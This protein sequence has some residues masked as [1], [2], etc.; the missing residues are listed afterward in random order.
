MI[1]Q[2]HIWVPQVMNSHWTFRS[3]PQS[4]S[5]VSWPLL[6]RWTTFVEFDLVCKFL[7]W[8]WSLLGSWASTPELRSWKLHFIRSV[9]YTDLIPYKTLRVMWRYT[10]T[11]LIPIPW[12]VTV[13][14]SQVVKVFQLTYHFHW[15]QLDLMLIAA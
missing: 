14:L 8:I 2:C 9:R 7:S 15:F 13:C 4:K 10:C 6:L 11:N 3:S 12:S 5:P 1:I